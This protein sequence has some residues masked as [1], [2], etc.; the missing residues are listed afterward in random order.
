MDEKGVTDRIN[1]ICKA[2]GWSYYRL[3]KAS[4]I[5]YSTLNTM[6]R[7]SNVPSVPS[8]IKICNGFGISL[9][10]F[11]SG[12]DETV[13]LTEDQKECLQCWN[14]LDERNKELALVY[15]KGLADSQGKAER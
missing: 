14:L 6:L 9:S 8:L 7:K 5:P 2:R 13:L 10:E 11:F 1:E 4:D 12:H 3:A 15:M